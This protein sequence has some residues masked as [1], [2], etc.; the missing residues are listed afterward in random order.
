MCRHRKSH[1]DPQNVK[2]PLNLVTHIH[3]EEW[4][5]PVSGWGGNIEESTVSPKVIGQR[6]LW[7]SDDGGRSHFC[8]FRLLGR[9][10]RFKFL[11]VLQKPNLNL[12]N[13]HKKETAIPIFGIAVRRRS[14]QS[15]APKQL[16]DSEENR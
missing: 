4:F 7:Y 1:P 10:F 13:S 12:F 16:T 2:A 15:V 9:G 6:S 14:N 8:H 11:R 5:P 3:M